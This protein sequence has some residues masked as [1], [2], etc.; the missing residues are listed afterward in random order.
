MG[1]RH[2]S[3]EV[4]VMVS[5]RRDKDRSRTGEYG[6]TVRNPSTPARAARSVLVVGLVNSPG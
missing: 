5:E 6:G 1:D 4:A 2:E 3:V